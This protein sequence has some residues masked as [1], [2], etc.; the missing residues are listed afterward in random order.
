MRIPHHS[1]L[2]IALGSNQNW[3]NDRPE[4]VIFNAVRAHIYNYFDV[5]AESCLYQ[6]PSFPLGSGAD[7]INGCVLVTL[8]NGSTIVDVFDVLNVLHEI[9]A[10]FGRKRGARWASR[11]L[12]LDL[13]AI[14]GLIMPDRAGY[15]YWRDL[16]LAEQKMQ[17]PAT[18]ILPHPRMQDR[19]F[20]LVPLAEIAPDWCHPVSGLT[21][22]QMLAALPQSDVDEVIPI[23]QA[24]SL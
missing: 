7:Y 8:R 12:D 17:T 2:L 18:L 19:A 21:V 9:E 13:L 23:G 24:T 16:P 10:R 4:V 6:S 22:A 20:V 11:S 15:E 1:Q 14:D 3:Q 5:I